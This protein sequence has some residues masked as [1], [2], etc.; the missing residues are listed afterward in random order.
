[1]PSNT[2][3]HRLMTWQHGY[4]ADSTYTCG[5]FRELAPAWMDLAALLKG[6]PSPRRHGA[7][8][9]A[10][11]ELGSGMGLGLCL[12]AATHPEGQ[13][14]GIDFQPDHILH[15][16]RLAEA[17]GLS[18]IR[19]EEADFLALAAD[20]AQ[21]RGMHHYVVAHGIATWITPVIRQALL[22]LAS[23]ALRPGGLF[24]CSYNTTPG[25]LAGVPLQQL[26][27]LESRRRAA[28]P[29]G[30]AAA[31][32]AAAATLT[33]L[34]GSNEQPSALARNLPGLRERLAGLAKQDGAYQVQEY[35]NEGWQPLPVHTL[36]AAAASCKLRYVAS[37]SLPENFA[38]LL[39]ASI[40]DVISAESDPA[41]RETLQDLAINQSFRRDL[42]CHGRDPLTTVE[43]NEAFSGLRVRLLDAPAQKNYTF[44]C[45]FGQITTTA[46][47]YAG[48]EASIADGVGTFGELLDRH[49]LSLGALAQLLSL[50]LHSGRLGL[51]R[52]EAGAAAIETCRSVTQVLLSLQ[53]GGRP[54]SFLPVASI[55]S[56]VALSLPE[57]L[58]EQALHSQP[59]ADPLPTLAAGLERLGRRLTTEPSDALAAW[60]RRQPVLE[61]LGVILYPRTSTQ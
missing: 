10:Y 38:G 24:Y 30:A 27:W 13:F 4:H 3:A 15:S 6:Q 45:S 56:A 14:T 41:L 58:L 59:D 40:R 44:N 25:W 18:N 49:N 52:G 31:V 35:L 33:A 20:P 50:L 34:L 23:D 8:P 7:E 55:G 2:N 42:F 39:P 11:L 19:F 61:A 28:T 17:L 37:A 26:A 43:L 32:S 47:L 46:E 16:R 48:V 36:H 53:R 57:A 5:F 9:F 12:L 60:Q 54:Y 29:A 1:M 51:D 21:L 22:Q